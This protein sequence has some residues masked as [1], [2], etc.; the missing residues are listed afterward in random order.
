MIFRGT[1]ASRYS[2]LFR[3]KPNIALLRP[4]DDLVVIPEAEGVIDSL[5]AAVHIPLD[6]AGPTDR[7][8]RWF[9]RL[10]KIPAHHRTL[11]FP[12]WFAK[13]ANIY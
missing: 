4:D 11:N 7:S 12:V 1:E 2:L 8:R 3:A 6:V 9:N 13:L 10:F 5:P